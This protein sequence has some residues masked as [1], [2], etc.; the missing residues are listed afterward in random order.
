MMNFVFGFNASLAQWLAF[1]VGPYFSA[2]TL[3][4]NLFII[5]LIMQVLW[6][7]LL[8]PMDFL[9]AFYIQRTKIWFWDTDNLYRQ[10][11]FDAIEN[12]YLE[13]SAI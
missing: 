9:I 12:S 11:Y 8:I 3:A 6:S 10:G 1:F 5:P 7:W 2:I 4:F 13:T